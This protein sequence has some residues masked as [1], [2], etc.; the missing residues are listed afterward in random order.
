MNMEL[1]KGQRHRAV[2][3]GCCS[4][5]AIGYLQ[6][7]SFEGRLSR[8]IRF[9]FAGLHTLLKHPKASKPSVRVR[10]NREKALWSKSRAMCAGQ[11]CN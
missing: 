11:V 1:T 10:Q 9:R 5:K 4:S 7:Q 3:L 6:I 8:E 2:S